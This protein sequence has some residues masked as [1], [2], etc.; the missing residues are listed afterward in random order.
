MGNIAYNQ[1]SVYLDSCFYSSNVSEGK[2]T[3]N[4]LL[5]R[6]VEDRVA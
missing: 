1:A 5:A 2:L 3:H 6:L 4:N